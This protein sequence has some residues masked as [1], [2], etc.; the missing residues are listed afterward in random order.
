MH[1]HIQ[2]NTYTYKY[3]CIY[4]RIYIYTHIYTCTCIH[5]HTHIN[6]IHA[7]GQALRIFLFGTCLSVW[8]ETPSSHFNHLT[9]SCPSWGTEQ[10]WHGSCTSKESGHWAR[11]AMR[12]PPVHR[13]TC[14]CSSP[15]DFQP[16]CLDRNIRNLQQ[17]FFN[18]TPSRRSCEL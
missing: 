11:I 15:K 10:G 18:Q 6:N 13:W 8:I 5:T 9:P 16:W 4:M 3:M 12:F 17:A 1:M 2:S 7:Q 14:T